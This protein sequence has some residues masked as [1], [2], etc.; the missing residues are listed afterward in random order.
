ME[1]SSEKHIAEL[2]DRAK[3]GDND[4]WT[5]LV[6]YFR[7]YIERLAGKYGSNGTVDIDDLISVG[8]IGFCEAVRHFDPSKGTSLKTFATYYITGA[9]NDE[10]RIALNPTGM[11]TAG[12][13]DEETRDILLSYSSVEELSEQG[14]DIPAPDIWSKLETEISEPVK[15]YDDKA[16]KQADNPQE[17]AAKEQT[18][19]VSEVIDN[20]I[21]K[22]KFSE[23][24]RALQILEVLKKATDDNHPVNK[25]KLAELLKVYRAGKY[26]NSTPTK[27]DNTFTRSI[28]EILAEVD[29]LNYTDENDDE[30][31]IRYSGYQEDRL[32]QKI[33]KKKKGLEI[34]DFTYNHLFSNDEL[35]QLINV[36]SLSAILSD[37]DRNNLVSKILSTASMYYENPLWNGKKLRYGAD[38]I[39]GRFLIS[40]DESRKKLAEN[41]YRIRRAICE[42]KQVYFYF[43]CHNE[44][45]EVV[46]KN[47]RHHILSPY[48]LVVY[49]DQYYCIGLRSDD[50]QNRIWH[51]RLDLMSDIQPYLDPD[52]KEKMIEVVP[53]EGLPIFNAYWDPEKYL[54]EHLN[55]GFDEPRE[56]RI[57]VR[58]DRYNL[59]YDSFSNHYKKV[60]E[61]EE[62]GYDIVSVKTS[63]YMIVR[64]ALQHSEYVEVLNNDIR[65][66]IQN[67][68][69]EIS[70]RY[71]RKPED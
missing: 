32:D 49:N 34:T 58:K 59:L 37:D 62:P 8:M 1:E 68:T 24:R 4:A 11:N 46:H 66:E 36:I 30:Y 18:P 56:V 20:A 67:L 13:K 54:A 47:E 15:K 7:K 12:L 19:D 50:R 53:F 21:D 35:D 28:E 39:Q 29:P 70:T 9:I 40:D 48:H 41:I 31:L 45:H 63:P 42:F 38:G 65:E 10:L 27:A 51:Y 23:T 16:E 5:E 3:N 60:R 71:G 69:K 64:W 43:N 61:A 57:K 2:V 26:N 22:G 25:E 55:M 44:N 52:G 14:L 6:N 33:N 17:T